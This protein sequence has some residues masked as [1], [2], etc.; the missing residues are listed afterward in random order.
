MALQLIEVGQGKALLKSVF[1]SLIEVGQGKALLTEIGDG[2][3]AH[4][5]VLIAS[6]LTLNRTAGILHVQP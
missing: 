4:F 1:V 3:F 2:P 6:F 5:N